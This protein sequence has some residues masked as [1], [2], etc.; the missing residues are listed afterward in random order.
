MES[1]SSLWRPVSGTT[2]PCSWPSVFWS[3]GAGWT[4]R[5]RAADDIMQTLSL[6][7]SLPLPLSL[8]VVHM[9]THTCRDLDPASPSAEFSHSLEQDKQMDRPLTKTIV[10][11]IIILSAV[12]CYCQTILDHSETMTHIISAFFLV[13]AYFGKWQCVWKHP[14]HWRQRVRAPSACWQTPHSSVTLSSSPPEYWMQK[15][16]QW[17][18]KFAT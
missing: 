5:R 3:T 8:F 14:K 10:W 17:W 18:N 1:S 7:F 9:C 15:R 16:S 6:S 12:Q 13:L 2:V 11:N 4:H